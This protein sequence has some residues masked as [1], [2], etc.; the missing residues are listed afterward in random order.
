MKIGF[1]GRGKILQNSIDSF[2]AKGF[3]VPFIISGKTPS[4]YTLQL[5]D[6]EKYANKKKIPFYNTSKITVE[7]L[8]SVF[9]GSTKADICISVNFASIISQ[10]VIDLFE[11]G[12][13]NA[14]GGDLP[15]YRGNACQ[16]WAIINRENHIGLSI[17]RMIGGEVDSGLILEKNLYP[18]DINTRIGNVYDW[19]EKDSPDLFV[20][21]V[22]KLVANKDY[23]LEKQNEEFALRCY[24][25]VPEDGLIK[26]D[27]TAES[28]VRL[29]N[30][31]SEPY[32]G[33]FAYIGNEKVIIWRARMVASKQKIL[34]VPGQV[35][36]I[37]NKGV[38]VA[39]GNQETIL[40]ETCSFQELDKVNPQSFIKSIRTRFK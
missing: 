31:S 4:D 23:F 15:R 10:K 32:A 35:L 19:F 18:I 36:S 26:W 20:S 11:Y 24:P 21:A 16:A 30:A 25:R 6:L 37:D 40:I 1:I 27:Q 5:E 12:I 22:E 3:Q 8:N 2:L 34:A 9:S 28:I 13:L 29:I 7:F 38:E 14:H 39:V 33:A 17:H